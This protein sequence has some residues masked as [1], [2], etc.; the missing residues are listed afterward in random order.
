MKQKVIE[1][2]L[3][4]PNIRTVE[5]A[6]I[7]DVEPD[8][9]RPLVAAEI[10]S[11]TI[12]EE[13]VIAP[14]GKTVLSFRFFSSAPAAAAVAATLAPEPTPA[15]VARTM[16]PTS[17]RPGAAS[18]PAP[19]VVKPAISVSI[20]V[21]VTRKLDVPI[22]AAASALPSAAA[23]R[24]KSKAASAIE[25]L[26]GSGPVR[27]ASLKRA[28][29]LSSSSHPSSYLKHA[30]QAGR[31]LY[32]APGGMWSAAGPELVKAADA[33]PQ[34]AHRCEAQSVDMVAS[35]SKVAPAHAPAK[36][37]Q[38]VVAP[39]VAVPTKRDS[40]ADRFIAGVLS[41]GSLHL[42]IPGESPLDLP[43]EHARALWEFMQT[44]GSAAW[45]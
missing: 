24:G 9:V 30:I 43:V 32:D 2:I 17:K 39:V 29:G 20:D 28:M 4:R 31:I 44:H 45:A 12:V 18:K 25:Y 7:F 16:P 21:P 33:A 27:T 41:D 15:R 5:I 19:E 36:D 1:L 10:A 35:A 37:A 40:G 34:P 11:G 13:P 3:N 26:R 23:T 38:G 6:D 22:F 8:S 14:N 42:R